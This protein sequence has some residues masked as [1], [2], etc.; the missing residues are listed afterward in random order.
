MKKE[1][2]LNQI[3]L[4]KNLHLDW[5]Y[6]AKSLINEK[7]VL[8]IAPVS[9]NECLFGQWFYGEGQKLSSL[10]NNPLECM[11][12]MANLHK[13]LHDTYFDIF[14]I[15]APDESK[16]SLMG[17]LFG[18]KKRTISP[19]EI[20]FAATQLTKL[21]SLSQTLLD[22]LGRLERRIV[23]VSDEKLEALG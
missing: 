10:S 11:T 20:A 9:P 7:S 5:V 12:N 14:K 19:E 2:I 18:E 16:K 1:A 3:K 13:S 23:A 21:E 6:K 8:D 4:A 17:K 15:Y 22:E